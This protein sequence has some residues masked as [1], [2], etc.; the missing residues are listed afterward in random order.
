V[1]A[2]VVLFEEF[3]APDWA[4][5]PEWAGLLLAQGVDFRVVTTEESI[6]E[7]CAEALVR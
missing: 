6:S 3:A 2:I 1:T 7:L 5:P 4:Q